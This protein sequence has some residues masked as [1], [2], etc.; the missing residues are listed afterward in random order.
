[1]LDLSGHSR[2]SNWS[3][4]WV[5]SIKT[6]INLV[7]RSLE[8]GG[9]RDGVGASKEVEASVGALSLPALD[10]LA[11]LWLTSLSNSPVGLAG[12]LTQGLRQVV[13][14]LRAIAKVQL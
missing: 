13:Q 7:K 2:D 12:V 8:V 4:A 11:E 10:F 9:T 3:R 5:V 6:F 1:M 14:D